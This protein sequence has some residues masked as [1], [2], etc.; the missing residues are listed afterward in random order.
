VVSLS[1]EE[2]AAIETHVARLVEMEKLYC[3]GCK[4]CQPCPQEVN[5]PYI[6]EMYNLGKVYGLWETA[7]ANYASFPSNS[8][9]GGKQADACIECGECEPKCP[10]K[11]AIPDLLK[12]AHEALKS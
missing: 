1:A 10:Q 3:T 6:F 9:V 2:K 5:I 8:W 11:L 7:E 12:V 4:Y